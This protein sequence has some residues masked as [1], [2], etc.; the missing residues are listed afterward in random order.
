MKKFLLSLLT[1]VVSV[2]SSWAEGEVD[3]TQGW[4][5]VKNSGYY[6][7]Y[8]GSGNSHKYGGT[9]YVANAVFFVFESAGSNSY[10]WK[11]ISNNRY[12]Y[13]DDSNNIVSAASKDESNDKYKWCI[14]TNGSNVNITTL[15]NY[16]EGNPTKVLASVGDRVSD[17]LTFAEASSSTNSKNL[18]LVQTNKITVNTGETRQLSSVTQNGN[19]AIIMNGGKLVVDAAHN[20]K[21]F[22][23]QPSTVEIGGGQSFDGSK[24]LSNLASLTLDGSGT[25]SNVTTRAT[26]TPKLASNWTGIVQVVGT[27][28]EMNLNNLGTA[29]SYVEFKGAN[30]YF[31]K[32]NPSVT[33]VPNLILTDNG[34]TM[35]LNC[36]NG[37]DKD[38][39][40]FSGSVSGTGTMTRND[41]GTHQKFVFSGDVSRWTGAFKHT[42]TDN[43][44]QKNY[45]TVE[46]N[47]SATEINATIAEAASSNGK[48]CV[49]ISNDNPVNVNKTISK[50]TTL[51][52]TLSGTGTKTFAAN[53]NATKITAPATSAIGIKGEST[54]ITTGSITTLT[55][56]DLIISGEDLA[57]MSTDGT[58]TVISCSGD[59]SV[60]TVTLNGL[61][62]YVAAGVTYAAIKNGN[63]IE[64]QACVERSTVT[65]KFGTVCL[66]YDATTEG[67]I[68]YSA[69]VNANQ[70]V[71]ATVAGNEI[72]AGKSYI[73]CSTGA[74]QTFVKKSDGN[75]EE[76]PLNDGSELKG[77]FAE[78][79]APVGSYVLQ[80]ISDVQKF[81]VVVDGQQPTV[82]AYR[83]YIETTTNPAR[84]MSIELGEATGIDALNAIV[85]NNVEVYDLA[86]RKMKGLHKG[87]NIVNGAKVIVK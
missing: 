5:Q 7:Y 10:Y 45:T 15:D 37:W 67:V 69:T 16:N 31:T 60:E 75:T 54:V 68:L 85:N 58:R 39:R 50:G 61:E 72:E 59:N 46:F 65:G 19:V 40:V 3:Y 81:R 80:T 12:L 35:A 79:L 28:A 11:D 38:E 24:V 30:G 27:I 20:T 14:I 36:S 63:N 17:W 6:F 84:E 21:V 51:E 66:P 44:E 57:A 82:G 34:S 86:G 18:T 64:I 53:V 56:L 48:L 55:T 29:N 33:Y 73:Y 87:I 32:A 77:T 2:G 70:V 23:D 41:K 1:L 49:I 83:C 76:A 43:E 4:Y 78:T 71:L 22:V 25:V 26:L 13:V 47:G 8:G 62:K 52:L 74:T 9:S 42:K